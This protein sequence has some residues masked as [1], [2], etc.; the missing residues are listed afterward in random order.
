MRYAEVITTGLDKPLYYSVPEMLE[1]RVV[2]GSGVF[3]P[4][5]PRQVFGI[6][7][8][9]PEKPDIGSARFKDIISVFD[10]G[11][12]IFG[13]QLQFADWIAS[14]YL[15]PR[16]KVLENMVPAY[17]KV[18]GS[19][20]FSIAVDSALISSNAGISP[21]GRKVLDCIINAGGKCMYKEL[22]AVAG[23][24]G[25]GRIL[26]SLKKS[27]LIEEDYVLPKVNLKVRKLV[28]LAKKETLSGSVQ[29]NIIE[30][31]EKNGPVFLEELA[32][33]FSY[34]PIHRL[35]KKG[36]L[37]VQHE[38]VRRL[39]YA[40][41]IKESDTA[42]YIAPESLT[43]E[44]EAVMK[45]AAGLLDDSKFAT[46]LLHGTTG[47]GKTE[48]YI[49]LARMVL[50]SGGSVIILIP[51][52]SLT[53]GMVNKFKVNFG[54]SVF[55]HHSRLSDGEKLDEWRLI[56]TVG[57]SVVIGARSAIFS[58]VRN[59]RMIVVDEEHDG[60][61]KQSSGLKYNGRDLAVVRGRLS[62]AL[63]VLGSA[64]PSI[65]S[66]YNAQ[67]GKYTYAAMR[68]RVD[69]KPMPDVEIVDM[70]KHSASI[71]SPPLL[72]EMKKKFD[73]GEQVLLF[74]NRRGFANSIICRDCGFIFQ[75]ENC[76]ISLTF[77][78]YRKRLCCHYC[79]YSRQGVDT[80]S[81]CKSTRIKEAG[82]G[83]ERVEELV[84]KHFPGLGFVRM[85][86]DTTR[87]RFAHLDII[88]AMEQG[89][90]GLLIGTQMVAKGHHLPGVTLV[91]VV[92]AD[93]TLGFPDFRAAERTFQLLVQVAG[94]AGRGD[95]PGRVIIQ[96]YNPEHYCISFAGS[97]DYTSFY[98]KEIS[99]RK[100]LSYPPFARLAV[101]NISGESEPEVAGSA[102]ELFSSLKGRAG[103]AITMLGPVAAPVVRVK[104]RFRWQILLKSTDIL[105]MRQLLQDTGEPKRNIHVSVDIDPVS[106]T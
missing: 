11:Q 62:E 32:R 43:T 35:V 29:K 79:G 39:P 96:T 76:S 59:L 92:M 16:S 90:K 51:E 19:R 20:R 68:K 28:S 94:R 4:V 81:E 12:V 22:A 80:C 61:Y 48:I 73:A 70:R 104:R 102:R 58:P 49:R 50:N 64:T 66:Y 7:V 1:A 72:E 103:R 18:K 77:H 3:V 33:S 46:L 95:K 17:L 26:S 54:E 86:S 98:E 83:T 63:V 75:C 10:G 100:E 23:K 105:Q 78:K 45:K 27:G 85:D 52:I 69:D 25:L 15:Y 13:D 74:V 31:L 91:G 71:L 9:Q 99:F 6:V 21:S 44:Q 34:Q 30:F 101:V 82:F 14:Y 106:F 38:E 36:V 56:R 5:G 24:S 93:L 60:S 8:S 53:M 42:R 2:I 41:R 37:S 89:E 57:S 87:S 65:E 88:R 84:L 55:I 67:V 97:Y 47:S 40:G